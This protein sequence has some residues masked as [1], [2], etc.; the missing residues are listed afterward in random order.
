M[1]IITEIRLFAQK[2]RACALAHMLMT[3]KHAYFVGR[4]VKEEKQDN[5]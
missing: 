5:G 4:L 2:G 1:S 3:E